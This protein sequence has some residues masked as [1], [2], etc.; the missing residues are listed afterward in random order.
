MLSHNALNNENIRESGL[1]EIDKIR[2]FCL[3]LW[4][5][6]VFKLSF[7]WRII[8]R[9]TEINGANLAYNG[10]TIVKQAKQNFY[11]WTI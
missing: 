7:I 10:Y 6:V 9:K 2:I 11:E 1:R 5:I 8:W 3:V 4:F